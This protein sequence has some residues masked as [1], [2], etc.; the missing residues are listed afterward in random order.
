LNASHEY[1][2]TEAFAAEFNIPVP[3][4]QEVKLTYRVRMRY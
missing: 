3:E 1:A 4:D 2:K